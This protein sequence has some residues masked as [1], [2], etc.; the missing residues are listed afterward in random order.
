MDHSWWP[1]LETRSGS[2]KNFDPDLGYLGSW[3]DFEKNCVQLGPRLDLCSQ[4]SGAPSKLKDLERIGRIGEA[5]HCSICDCIGRT[6]PKFFVCLIISPLHLWT[7][8]PS[9]PVVLRQRFQLCGNLLIALSQSIH[10]VLLQQPLAHLWVLY[11]S[12]EYHTSNRHRLFYTSV[13]Q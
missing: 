3:C 7:A 11:H 12:K 4:Q 13:L 10:H 5:T 8:L 2:N 9:L 6:N 1:V